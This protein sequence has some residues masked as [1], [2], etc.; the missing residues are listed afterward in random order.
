MSHMICSAYLKR[1]IYYMPFKMAEILKTQ[2][3]VDISCSSTYDFNQDIFSFNE[4]AYDSYKRSF[5]KSKGSPENNI[6][7]VFSNLISR[8]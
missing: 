6:W 3:I 8:V 7:E 5:I 2:A 4:E 1:E